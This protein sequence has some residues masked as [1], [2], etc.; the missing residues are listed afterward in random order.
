MKAKP[1]VVLFFAFL[2]MFAFSLGFQAYVN[3]ARSQALGSYDHWLREEYGVSS[4]EEL[5]LKYEREAYEKVQASLQESDELKQHLL[6][7]Q[8]L[9]SATGT[10]Q[11]VD[12]QALLS[13]FDEEESFRREI[14]T[15]LSSVT[16][17]PRPEIPSEQPTFWI[18]WGNFNP[19]MELSVL[20]MVSMGFTGALLI[21]KV[22]G[23]FERKK[24]IYLFLALFVFV[25]G[26]YVGRVI[27]SGS[28]VS[29]EPLSFAQEASYVIRVDGTTIQ[30][31]NGS[32]GKIDYSGTDA[33]TV[34]QS[35]I[36]VLGTTGG[37][38]F[39]KEGSYMLS[40][41]LILDVKI[42]LIGENRG[43]TILT[44]TVNPLIKWIGKDYVEVKGFTLD[45]VNKSG[46]GIQ[47]LGTWDTVSNGFNVIEDLTVKN[48]ITAILLNCY[49][50]GKIQNIRIE[51]CSN[52]LY[53][54]DASI[55][56]FIS[57]LVIKDLSAWGIYMTSSS[58]RSEGVVFDKLLVFNSVGNLAIKDGFVILFD[59]VIFDYGA[60]SAF[61]EISGGDTIIFNKC[62]FSSPDIND[63]RV[64]IQPLTR[65][66]TRI[67]FSDCIFAW[68]KYYGLTL[69]YDSESGRRPSDVVVSKS[70]FMENGLAADGGDILINNADKVRIID[71]E[72]L[73]TTPPYNLAE[74]NSPT[75]IW[76]IRNTF[77]K[78]STGL[79]LVSGVNKFHQNKGY[80]TEN[81]G[82]A[83]GTSPIEVA[84]GLVS[85]PTF[86]ILTPQASQPYSCS[87]TANSTHITIYHSASGSISVSWY[88][89]V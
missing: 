58:Q 42:S 66:L 9:S 43:S 63:G 14:A 72:L 1:L 82:T 47:V 59:E 39:I 38:I 46:D 28:E 56:V 44:G 67:T 87:Y 62:Y 19:F 88:A 70:K 11:D 20:S 7:M 51:S 22:R 8:R 53:F 2:F 74:T 45:G 71:S 17:P 86:V 40:S 69:S 60:R 76:L 50:E 83:T 65:T 89:E 34:I 21:P 84:H 61:I 37:K 24:L 85:T 6:S 36:D 68:N 4:I 75:D 33:S 12:W 48:C 10:N 77:A 57:E 23:K 27:A 29:I 5:R 15:R 78:G 13:R 31:I 79:L 25:W 18:E 64:L 55:N 73:S 54:Q 32:T 81:S 35:A 30:A 41:T 80:V 49:L 3:Q 52:G 26:F 16:S